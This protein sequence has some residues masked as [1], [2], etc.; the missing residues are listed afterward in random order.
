MILN[1]RGLHLLL[2]PIFILPCLSSSTQA[3]TCSDLLVSENFL[4]QQI[5]AHPRIAQSYT[6][7][8]FARGGPLRISESLEVVNKKLGRISKLELQAWILEINSG[9]PELMQFYSAQTL[10]GKVLDLQNLDGEFD[11]I[12]V[13]GFN[14]QTGFLEFYK[15]R[16]KSTNFIS[17]ADFYE[18]L[19]L[20]QRIKFGMEFGIL[21][22]S[23]WFQSIAKVPVKKGK[24]KGHVLTARLKEDRPYANQPSIM[25]LNEIEAIEVRSLVNG[26]YKSWQA[27]AIAILVRKFQELARRF[28]FSASQMHG[29]GKSTWISSYPDFQLINS[30]LD[31]LSPERAS[32]IRFISTSAFETVPLMIFAKAWARDGRTFISEQGTGHFHDIFLHLLGYLAMPP[33]IVLANRAHLDFW[34]KVYEHPVLSQDAALR[35]QAEKFIEQWATDFD[36]QTGRFA[37]SVFG[38]L[39]EIELRHLYPNLPKDS[40]EYIRKNIDYR[41]SNFL[42]AMSNKLGPEYFEW[43]LQNPNHPARNRDLNLTDEQMKIIRSIPLLAKKIPKEQLPALVKKSKQQLFIED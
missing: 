11:K 24:I 20:K 33:E 38:A 32:P 12:R 5:L 27:P 1:S 10:R 16:D 7:S 3:S 19:S 39:S 31:A 2:L 14:I 13:Q 9:G 43:Q 26:Y 17:G 18:R 4:S 15:F 23:E 21:P 34:I 6:K 42:Y 36:N 25:K 41:I 37:E 22:E 30:V 35:L 8:L 40:F 29:Q 28:Y